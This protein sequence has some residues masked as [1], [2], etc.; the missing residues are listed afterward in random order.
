MIPIY[1]RKLYNYSMKRPK[2]E[3]YILWIVIILSVISLFFSPTQPLLE[4]LKAS[5]PWVTA[6]IL[7]SEILLTIGSLL[8][9]SV[10]TPAF[11]K[12]LTNSTKSALIGI[13]HIKKTVDELDWTPVARK[14]NDSKLFWLGFW[15]SI[16]GASG[17]GIILIIAIGNTLPITSWGLMIL[18]F[19]D[20]G[21]TLVIRRAIYRGVK[22]DKRVN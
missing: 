13:L 11:I 7:L 12:S 20:L 17:D 10:A 1:S 22:A 8:M 19:W 16:V 2:Y 6:G 9:L 18:P 14:C 15:I 3:S 5:L 4:Q 21:L